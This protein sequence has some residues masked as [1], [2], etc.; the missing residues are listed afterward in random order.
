MFASQGS[1]LELVTFARPLF[2]SFPKSLSEEKI[3]LLMSIELGEAFENDFIF[4]GRDKETMPVSSSS[5]LDDS[6]LFSSGFSSFSGNLFCS[7]C[8]IAELLSIDAYDNA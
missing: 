7:F 4:V 8:S 6:F 5:F 3:L 1:S 2:A